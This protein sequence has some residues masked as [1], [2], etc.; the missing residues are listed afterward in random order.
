MSIGIRSHFSAGTGALAVETRE[1][2]RALRE[3]IADLPTGTVIATIAA[4]SG[5]LKDAR[6]G[7]NIDNTERNGLPA[8]YSWAQSAPAR[9]VIVYDFHV[10]IN[11]PGHWRMLIESLPGLRSPK[12]ARQTDPASLVIFVGPTF[13]LTPQNPLRGALPILPFSPPDRAA[14][15]R[16]AESL[17]AIPT[18]IRENVIDSLCGLPADAAEQ[19]A[20]EVLARGQGWNVAALQSAKTRELKSAGLEI[21][22]PE[23]ELG[24]LAGLRDYCET[25]VFPWRND[26]QLSVRRILCAGL[27]GTG[28]SYSAR[29]IASRLGTKAARLSIPALKAGIVGASEGNLRRALRVIDSMSAESPLVVVLDE[30][31]TIA[32]DGLDGGTSSGMF[33]ELLTWLQESKSQAIVLATLNRLDK[34]DA[35]LESRFQARFFVDLPTHAERRA[36]AAIHLRRLRC[37]SADDAAKAVADNTEGFSSREIAESLIPDLAALTNRKPDATTTARLAAGITPASKS[38]SEQ[39]AQMRRAAATLRRANDADDAAPTPSRRQVQSAP[40]IPAI[41]PTAN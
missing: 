11:N 7:R 40:F 8:A 16:T 26:P 18:D 29:W 1:E 10:L 32:R 39:L 23:P 27:P 6:T 9:V 19:C 31:D 20:A 17:H 4:P 33:A 22:E 25:R 3:I 14:I 38:Q 5:A 13:E 30:I 28:K 24:G 15:A 21:W 37:E 41:D 35:A 36:V 2:S 34:L 12:G